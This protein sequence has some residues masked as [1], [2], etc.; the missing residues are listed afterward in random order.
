MLDSALGRLSHAATSAA[1][2]LEDLSIGAESESVRLGAARSVLDYVVR[3]R[4][5]EDLALRLQAV[6]RTLAERADEAA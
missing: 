4:E 5:S 6:E 3:L 1:K 2:T